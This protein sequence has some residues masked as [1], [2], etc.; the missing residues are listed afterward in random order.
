MEEVRN[1]IIYTIETALK[2]A[3]P[4]EEKI[5]ICFDLS[6]LALV[7]MDY[8][9]VKMLIN[10]LAF[11]YP[12]ILYNALVVNAPFFFWACWAVIKPWIDPVTAAKVLFLKKSALSQYIAQDDLNEL[13]SPS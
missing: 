3:K 11:N 5:T 4:D 6:N 8:E 13:N 7:N 10:M 1:F 2:S 9:A 12:E